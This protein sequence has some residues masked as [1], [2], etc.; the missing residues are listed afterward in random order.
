MDLATCEAE[1]AR[2]GASVRVIADD[3][4]SPGDVVIEG[5]QGIIDGRLRAR[6]DALRV[7]LEQRP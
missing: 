2:S 1:I 5:R 4:L 3:S 6:L 7:T